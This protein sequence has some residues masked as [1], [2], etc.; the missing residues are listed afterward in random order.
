MSCRETQLLGLNL[1]ATF[2]NCTYQ[3]AVCYH[4]YASLSIHK[5]F[6]KIYYH[7]GSNQKQKMDMHPFSMLS[8]NLSFSLGDDGGEVR[9]SLSNWRKAPRDR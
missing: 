6:S 7:T 8:I 2:T 5:D 3:L 1:T 4:L 9:H